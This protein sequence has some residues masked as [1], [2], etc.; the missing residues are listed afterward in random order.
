M[1]PLNPQ[2]RASS[3]VTTATSTVRCFQI[4]FA[5]SISSIS[6][7]RAENCSAH[8]KISSNNP[9]GRSCETPPIRKYAACIRAPE[10]RS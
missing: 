9:A 10:T 3:E 6:S 1:G 4:R 5:V 8:W 2:S 7:S